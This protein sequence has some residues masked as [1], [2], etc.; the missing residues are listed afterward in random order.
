MKT[1]LTAMTLAIGALVLTDAASASS[2]SERE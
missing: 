1:L 2:V